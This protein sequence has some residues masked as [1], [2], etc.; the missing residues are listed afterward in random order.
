MNYSLKSSD[1]KDTKQNSQNVQNGGRTDDLF[2][3][4]NDLSDQRQS[5]FKDKDDKK[6][7]DENTFFN[8]KIP[9]DLT[10]VYSLTYNN[11]R[12]ENLI[13]NNSLV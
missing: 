8:Y 7:A 2:G 13:G 5:L 3:R 4:S 9:W 11:A 1:K 10:F 6:D 12:R